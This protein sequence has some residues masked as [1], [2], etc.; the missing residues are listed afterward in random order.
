MLWCFKG[1]IRSYIVLLF[2]F[3]IYGT[4]TAHAQT[5]DMVRDG[6][7]EFGLSLLLET[8][9]KQQAVGAPRLLNSDIEMVTL[10]HFGGKNGHIMATNMR[11][12]KIDKNTMLKERLKEAIKASIRL[13]ANELCSSPVHGTLIKEYNVIYRYSYFDK[14]M[15]HLYGYDIT[16]NLC[17]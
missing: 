14:N 2:M 7:N 11:M 12:V 5:P 3:F 13:D 1:K 16:K 9:A 10:Q 15:N 4:S 6:V 8:M 17:K